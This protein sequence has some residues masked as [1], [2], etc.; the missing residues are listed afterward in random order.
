MGKILEC[1]GSKTFK[2]LEQ[3]HE[4]EGEFKRSP[5]YYLKTPLNLEDKNKNININKNQNNIFEE[6]INDLENELN[7]IIYNSD[8]FCNENMNEKNKNNKTNLASDKRDDYMVKIVDSIKLKKA[9][10]SKSFHK[11]KKKQKDN[12]SNRFNNLI[13]NK[14]NNEGKD[15]ALKKEIKK[16]LINNKSEN[17]IRNNLKENKITKKDIEDNDFKKNLEFPK[18]QIIK[19]IYKNKKEKLINYTQ[20]NNI[21][22][23][24]DKSKEKAINLKKGIIKNKSNKIKN[25]IKRNKSYQLMK[26]LPNSENITTSK[27]RHSLKEM[28]GNYKFTPRIKPKFPLY[29]GSKYIISLTFNEQ[30]RKSNLTSGTNSTKAI[31]EKYF[32]RNEE[33]FFNNKNTGIKYNNN[34][35]DNKS[36]KNNFLKLIPHNKT[37]NQINSFEN[38]QNHIKTEYSSEKNILDLELNNYRKNNSNDKINKYKKDIDE[39]DSNKN[40][41]NNRDIIKVKINFKGTQINHN[42]LN[43]SVNNIFILNYNMLSKISE[44][45]VLYDGN[46]YKVSNQE[47]SKLVLRY[48]Q[49]TKRYF[50]YYNN[51]HSLVAPNVKPLEVFEIKN[52][53]NIEIIDINLLKN[54]NEYKIKFA[55]IINM[56]ENINFYIFAT[57]DKDLGMNVINILNLIKKFYDEGK[58][59]FN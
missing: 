5:F 32:R 59:L 39:N 1:G 3:C 28:K 31:N 2:N 42:L 53:R 16:K 52:I 11:D 36:K 14:N 30:K 7:V 47:K 50:R 24:K 20:Y 44:K 54:K 6:Q 57:D 51:I 48:F 19:N 58:D 21:N 10:L 33:D 25:N 41:S 37:E 18:N 22:F 46:I 45:A 15:D 43:N 17:N 4:I 34:T 8:E 26:P 13:D 40:I 12:N 49:I 55:F 29:K 23:D 56:I 38:L 9:K 27:F 35:S